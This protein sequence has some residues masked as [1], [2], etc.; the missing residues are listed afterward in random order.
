MVAVCPRQKVRPDMIFRRT[1][2]QTRFVVLYLRNGVV[3]IENLLDLTRAS[4]S[5]WELLRAMEHGEVFMEQQ[6][7]KRTQRSWRRKFAKHKG[8]TATMARLDRALVQ[9]S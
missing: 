8:L 9:V 7:S 4:M 5:I 6:H 3:L 1:A 2:S